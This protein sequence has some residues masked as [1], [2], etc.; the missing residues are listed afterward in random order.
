MSILNIDH[1]SPSSLNAF[2]YSRE[3]WAMRYLF[4]VKEDVPKFWRGK[5]VE[6]G[7]NALLHGEHLTG[8]NA[9]A[10]LSFYS[11]MPGELSDE[12]NAEFMKIGP[13]LEQ[14]FDVVHSFGKP[15]TTQLKIAHCLD[16]IPLPFLMVLDFLFEDCIVELKTSDRALV[17]QSHKRQGALYSDAKKM[18]VTIVCV[19][20]KKCI[21]HPLTKEEIALA[22]D[23]VHHLAESLIATISNRTP[24]EVLLECRLYDER[25]TSSPYLTFGQNRRTKK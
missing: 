1:L 24:Q 18:P 3:Q 25:K 10:Q 4:G 22:L 6:V 5:A 20:T 11:S 13:M 9:L 19:T 7:F 16:G 12:V 2:D 21:V 23:D 14:L 17:T 8:A 15:V